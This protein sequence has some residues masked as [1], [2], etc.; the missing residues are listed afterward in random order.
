MR[1]DTRGMVQKSVAIVAGAIALAVLAIGVWAGWS[2]TAQP[3]REVRLALVISQT[4][5]SGELS[6][7]SLAQREGNAVSDAL[8]ATGFDVTRERDLKRE[9]INRALDDFRVRLERAGPSA[10]GFVYYT[11]HGVQH[12]RTGDSYLLGI[13]ARLQGMSD[14][15]RYGLDMQSQRDGFAA[16]GAKAVFLVFDACRNVPSI[17]G[18]KASV[19]GLNRVEA[20]ADMLIAF[21][22][23]INSVAEEGVYAPILA[24]ELLRPGL[25]AEAAFAAV[26]RRVAL[27]T[28]RRQLPWTNNLLYNA[29]CFAGCAADTAPTVT[30]PGLTAP[31]PTLPAASATPP[32]YVDARKAPATMRAPLISGDVKSLPNFA[33]FRECEACPEMI[34]L[35]SGNFQTGEQSANVVF[36]KPFAMARAET[37]WD[38]WD[39]CVAGGACDGNGPTSVGGDEGWGRGKRP[40]V[41]VSWNDAVS[42]TKWLSQTTGFTYG[43]PSEA[44]WE[45]AARAASSADRARYAWNDK[46]SGRPAQCRECS[47]AVSGEKSAPTLSYPPNAWG[48]FD[49]S[50]NV[51]EFSADCWTDPYIPKA[52]GTPVTDACHVW[53]VLRGGGWRDRPTGITT[54][55]R[56]QQSAASRTD[57]AGFRVVRMH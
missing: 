13:D 25:T 37:S 7:V 42:Y 23:S 15:A 6:R 40:V 56:E 45:Y 14:L 16:T 10:V 30:S 26:Q 38:E 9:D 34:I 50:G 51:R 22:T 53:R 2:A 11:G 36:S 32:N 19:K 35:P 49:M 29:V 5:Y 47:N 48:L 31:Q 41:N 4:S 18:F 8:K 17:P 24:E 57:D 46:T 1:V 12:P 28:G 54:T 33:L 43:L 21:S 52:D 27:N 20:S 55:S 3:S 44:Q 39:A